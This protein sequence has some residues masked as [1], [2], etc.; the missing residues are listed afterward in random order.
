MLLASPL[1]IILI[2]ILAYVFLR[3]RL[4]KIQVIGIGVAIIGSFW[5]S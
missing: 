3:E 4:D 1:E 5:L 2:V